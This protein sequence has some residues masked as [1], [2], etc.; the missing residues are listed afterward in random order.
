MGIRSQICM[1]Y[2]R[3]PYLLKN[4]GKKKLKYLDY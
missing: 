4:Y 1:P 3:R 2:V